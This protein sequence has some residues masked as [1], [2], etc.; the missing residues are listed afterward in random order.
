MPSFPF[1][2]LLFFLVP[3]FGVIVDTEFGDDTTVESLSWPFEVD[4]GLKIGSGFRLTLT[5]SSLLP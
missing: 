2:F 1:D 3:A 4:I 5:V